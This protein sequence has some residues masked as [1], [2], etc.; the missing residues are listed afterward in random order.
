MQGNRA[1]QTSGLARA[2]CYSSCVAWMGE[3]GCF[4]CFSCLHVC[5]RSCLPVDP[6]PP[7]PKFSF[8]SQQCLNHPT[9]LG[10]PSCLRSS[11][12]FVCCLS[13]CK[14]VL[15]L[16]PLA[17]TPRNSPLICNSLPCTLSSIRSAFLSDFSFLERN[18][19]SFLHPTIFREEGTLDMPIIRPHKHY[20]YTRGTVAMKCDPLQGP[21]R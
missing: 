10:S 7:F 9:E 6:V 21:G 4:L 15:A 17:H 1:T 8:P 16:F 2:L 20:L 18:G 13:L 3:M 19:R 11:A 12:Q 5:S 14:C